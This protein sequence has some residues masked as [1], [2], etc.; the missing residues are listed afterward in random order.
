VLRVDAL[1]RDVSFTAALTRAVDAEIRDLAH[2]LGLALDVP[3]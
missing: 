1:H 3:G 2:W